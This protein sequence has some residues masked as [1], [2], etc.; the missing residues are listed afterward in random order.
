MNTQQ[1]SVLITGVGGG[2]TGEG[3]IK[4]LKLAATPYR[5]IAVDALP[6]SFGFFEV[7]AYEQVPSAGSPQYL[8]RILAICKRENV[9]V[10]IP[11]SEPEL[12]KMSENRKV[13][14][15]N[16]ILLLIN[17]AEVISRCMD[18]WETYLFLKEHGF[19][20][21]QSYLITEEQQID[22]I[23]LFPVV[24]KPIRGG[25]SSV[26]AFL[27]QDK[28][29]LEFFVRYLL[30]QGAVPVAQEYVGSPK[31]EYTTGV[32]H[33]LDGNFLGSIALR[34]QILSGLSSKIRIKNRTQHPYFDTLAISSGY[35][36]GLVGDY[37]SV[38]DYAERISQALHST[39][40][41]NVQCRK[42]EK[43]IYTF[44]INPRFSGT[45]VMRAMVGFNEPDILIRHHILGEKIELPI[46]YKTGIVARGLREQYIGID[47]VKN[48]SL[49]DFIEHQ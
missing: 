30:K 6:I 43:G 5:I 24:I 35:S 34:R 25:G 16:G 17:N 3:L 12:K 10:V 13:F 47:Q 9:Q 18:K 49:E 38:R 33:T 21:P 32:L 28:P 7:D 41:L 46:P 40:P 1:I 26:N 29:E 44:E 4:S 15:D 42:T 11:G 2:S 8:E 37:R 14:E 45:T 20:V 48:I 36:Q 39:G 23:G 27:A 31:E 19:D 22:E